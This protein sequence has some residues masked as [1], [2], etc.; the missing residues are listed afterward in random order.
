VYASTRVD[1]LTLTAWAEG[2]REAFVR[3]QFDAQSRFYREQ[4]PDAS[5]DVVLADGVPAGR[6][7]VERRPGEIRIMD[8]ALLTEHRGGGV[9]T[10]LLRTLQGEAERAGTPLT[11]HVEVFNVGA[12]RLY[13]RLGFQRVSERGAHLLLEWRPQE[14]TAS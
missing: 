3:Q 1:E 12:L 9:G 4:Y 5:Y 8:L 11:I 10:R 13:E 14:N 7:Y 6:L 2:E